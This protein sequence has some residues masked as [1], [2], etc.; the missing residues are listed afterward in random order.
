MLEENVSYQTTP[1]Q[2]IEEENPALRVL[3][4]FFHPRS[5]VTTLG[6]AEKRFVETL[7][8]FCREHDLEINVLEAAPSLLKN[9]GIQCKKDFVS[10]NFHGKGWLGTYLEWG[11]WILKAVPRSFSLF[12]RSRPN[13][14]FVPNNTLPNLALSYLINLTFKAPVCVVAHHV[15]APPLN[16]EAENCSLYSGYRTIKY[17]RLVSL[18]KTIAT[19]ITFPL[20]K[21]A[22]GI[23]AVS[24]FTAKTLSNMG[25][26]KAKIL[27]SGNAV[28]FSLIDKVKHCS[29]GEV[30]DGIFVGRIAKE[31]GIFDLLKVWKS[32]AKVRK[33]ARLLIIGS[34][35]EL[36]SVKERISTMGL[37][38]NVSLRG[39]CSE[40]ELYSLLKSS[41]L[42]IFPSLFEG[43]GIAVA[44][45]LACGLPVVAYDIPALRENFGKC[46][47]VFLVPAK[48]VASMT[49]TVLDIL[50]LRERE[51]SELSHYSKSYVQ[52]FSWEKV[53]K[54]DLRLLKIFKKHAE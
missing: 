18:S 22:K 14:V 29:S 15:D 20:L 4:V 46:E 40:T 6:G 25:V 48:N 32:V 38:H 10:L 45:A 41:R 31:K 12:R 23:I 52:Q 1:R 13:V 26:S 43:W 44:E 49:S 8:I 17:S 54:N 27:V 28:N 53:A 50:S 51:W 19:Y 36:P 42:F 33:N 39:Q 47:G 9:P 30:F 35:V 34:G 24:N 37:K 11:L 16:S 7:K 5:S 2:E 21:R 3:V